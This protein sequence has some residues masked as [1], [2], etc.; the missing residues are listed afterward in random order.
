MET[1][2]NYFIKDLGVMFGRSMR[3]VFRS[4]DTI[5]T[6]SITPIAIMLLF[7]YVF[8]GAIKTDK[9]N[10]VDYLLPGIMLMTIGSGIAYVA[11]RLF[12]D[13]QRGIFER[14]HSMPISRSTVLWGHVLTSIISNGISIVVIILVALLM[15]FRS[16]ASIIDWLAVFGILGI[17]TLALTWV[18]VIAGLAA[19]TPDGA[20]AFSYPIIFLPFISSA[21]VPTETMPKAVRLFAENQPVTPIVEAIRNL[22]SNQPVGNDIWIAISWCLGIIVIAYL[23]AMRLYKK[24]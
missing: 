19:K 9:E 24:I 4:M 23:F 8:G 7:V 10:Y 21:F 18:A 6:V 5:I 13:K 3:H 20:G 14:F 12:I 15:G 1:T 16:S 22:L 11:Y 2:K 17:F